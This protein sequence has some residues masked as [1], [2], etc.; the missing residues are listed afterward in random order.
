MPGASTS[1][2]DDGEESSARRRLLP[3]VIGYMI[4]ILIG[5]AVPQVAVAFYFGIAIYLIVPFWEVARLFRRP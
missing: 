5:L 4:A 3:A 1:P 2:Y